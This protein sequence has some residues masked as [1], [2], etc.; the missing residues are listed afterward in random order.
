MLMET[1]Q[2]SMTE[3][4]HESQFQVRANS[5]A[6]VWRLKDTRMHATRMTDR[7][8]R[9]ESW[10]DNASVEWLSTSI[11]HDLRNPLG[12]IYAAAEMLMDLDPG[13]TQLKRLATNIYRAAA[14]MREL[15]ADLNSVAR[16]NR[17]PAE[18]C[19][20]GDLIVRASEAASAGTESYSV[21]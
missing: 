4:P 1:E 19:D 18:M 17:S 6:G 20:I 2:Q 15:L 13:P 14:R 11:V 8:L 3:M 12:T 9:E 16:G 7:H 10:H 5:R 21:Q